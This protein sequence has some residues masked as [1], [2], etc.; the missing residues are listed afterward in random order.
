LIDIL[1]NFYSKFW[2]TD[3]TII[4]VYVTDTGCQNGTA[5]STHSVCT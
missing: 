4:H 3:H 5:D 2:Y 1:A